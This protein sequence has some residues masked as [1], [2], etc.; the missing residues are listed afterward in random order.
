MKT[1]ILAAL[2]ALAVVG[3]GVGVVAA[4]TV[5]MPRSS[6]GGMQ[7]GCGG[8]MMGGSDGGMMG[9]QYGGGMMGGGAD[10]GSCQQY[11][12][13]HNYSWDGNH[14]YGSGGMMD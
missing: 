6:T 5:S 8:G 7:G 13:E 9:G 4:Q 10:C 2:A 12:H 3:L 14:T 11:M 1:G